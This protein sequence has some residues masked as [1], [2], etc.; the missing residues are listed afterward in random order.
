MGPS[1]MRSGARPSLPM[2]HSGDSPAYSLAP[3]T[4][5]LTG[6]VTEDDGGVRRRSGVSS[7]ASCVFPLTGSAPLISML[8]MCCCNSL[9]SMPPSDSL[10]F[11]GATEARGVTWRSPCSASGWVVVSPF[12]TSSSPSQSSNSPMSSTSSSRSVTALQLGQRKLGHVGPLRI[13]RMHL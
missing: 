7:A 6:C 10:A 1:C 4:L 13:G 2:G 11:R 3:E 8:V 12:A 9:R 5:M